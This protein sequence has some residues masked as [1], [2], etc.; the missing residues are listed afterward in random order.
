MEAD[1][2][3]EVI[4][5]LLIILSIF[6]DVGLM[7]IALSHFEFVLWDIFESSLA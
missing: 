5:A 3:L 1:G 2:E 7:V 4:H 6:L